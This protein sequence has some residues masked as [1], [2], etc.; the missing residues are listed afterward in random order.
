MHKYSQCV[1][2]LKSELTKRDMLKADAGKKGSALL[3]EW[4]DESSTEEPTS[5]EEGKAHLM[6]SI[7]E[8]HLEA[9]EKV[10]VD[11]QIDKDTHDGKSVQKAIDFMKSRPADA[12]PFA[13]FLPL[14]FPH[15]PYSAPHPFAEM[16]NASNIGKIKGRNLPNKPEFHKLI[17]HYHQF[18][19]LEAHEMDTLMV[20]LR[21]TYL[22]MVSYSDA[23]LGR[24]LDFMDKSPLN[25][26]TV[27]M[28]WS[29]HGD[30]TGD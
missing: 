10:Q 6:A 18:D 22:G 24:L 2:A 29:D 26:N 25:D 19:L 14:S 27:I 5:A 15:P 1:T 3:E 28:V 12:P 30:Y 17:R 23:L 8:E 9:A 4:L 11:I 20:Q 13:V 16:Y 21:A 7:A